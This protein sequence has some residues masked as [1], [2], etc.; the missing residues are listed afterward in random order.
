LQCESYVT[1]AQAHARPELILEILVPRTL[2]HAQAHALTICIRLLSLGRKAEPR[3][4]HAKRGRHDNPEHV[5]SHAVQQYSSCSTTGRAQRA[6]A[7]SRHRGI[8]GSVNSL[9]AQF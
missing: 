8:A 2:L 1:A 5:M 9:R 6:V 3:G 7:A 4:E